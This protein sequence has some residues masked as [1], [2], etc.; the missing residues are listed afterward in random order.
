ME[1]PSG[2]PSVE[3]SPPGVAVVSVRGLL[4]TEVEAHMCGWSD[5]YSGEGGVVDRMRAAH[6]AS[7][8][9]A[10]VLDLRTPGG[11]ALGCLEASAQLEAMRLESGKPVY[12]FAL[13]ANSAGYALACGAA[14]PGCLFVLA[15][16]EAGCI[17]A[18]A[19][20]SEISAALAEAGEKITIFADPADKAA[21]NPYEPLSDVG[22][23]RLADLVR[24]SRERFAAFVSRARGLSEEALVALG[25]ASLR[26]SAAVDAGLCDGTAES[27]DEVVALA[28]A[29]IS[30]PS[31]V[32][33]AAQVAATSTAPKE[34]DSMSSPR[35]LSALLVDVPGLSAAPSDAALVA[36][37]APRLSLA[38]AVL[39]ATGESDPERALGVL[40]ARLATAALVPGLQSQLASFESAVKARAE[41]EEQARREAEQRV[42]KAERHEIVLSL[43][44]RGALEPVRAWALDGDGAPDPKLGPAERWATLPIAALRAMG[45]NFSASPL[46]APVLPDG[47]KP[48]GDAGAALPPPAR[49]AA[50]QSKDPARF[51]ALYHQLRGGSPRLTEV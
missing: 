40:E 2:P 17:G 3:A 34:L 8:V 39:V 15:S 35:A 31:P 21:T 33:P 4:S 47:A 42:E 43:V 29:S 9:G 44:K 46:V 27:L 49:D 16:G 32:A 51:G 12:V 41:A 37:L 10:V 24:S 23:E 28:L 22:R 19:V 13:E 50:T 6:E 14:S 5:G 26:G 36:A 7:T 1:P 25:G 11:D 30:A 48:L 20:H 45:E 38:K 18:V